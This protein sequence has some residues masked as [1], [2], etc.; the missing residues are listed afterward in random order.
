M[1]NK[2][3]YSYNV[4]D[5]IEAVKETQFVTNNHPLSKFF[6]NFNFIFFVTNTP[7]IGEYSILGNILFGLLT[8]VPILLAVAFTTLAERKIMASLQRRR[9]PNVVGSWGLGQPII[10]GCK[11]FFKETI[12]PGRSNFFL[13]WCTP[14]LSVSFSL[15]GWGLIAFSWSKPICD[16]NLGL[17]AIFA[18][19]SL[20]TYSL[21]IAA[22]SSNSRYSLLGC[23]RAV[24]Q[25][26]SYELILGFSILFVAH[27]SD[28]LNLTSIVVAQTNVFFI[29]PL[30]PIAILFFI[31]MLA[32][33]NRVPFDLPEAE[34]ELVSGYSTEYS[35]F[36][37]SLIMIAE[38]SNIL[39]L[40]SLW[41]IMF[42][43]GWLSP[44]PFFDF[45]AP[46]AIFAFK[47]TFL[48]FIF[49]FARSLL[50][51]YRFDQLMVICWKLFIPFLIGAVILYFGFVLLF[52]V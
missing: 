40:S 44:L 17:F 33:T 12:L 35:A 29:F 36:L 7:F 45:L 18:L 52:M 16:A 10:D 49:I 42:W 31:M 2:L 51:R 24:S 6:L 14:L 25:L 22:W 8:I 1:L 19:A 30:F 43:G 13:F 20:N 48:V 41:V 34:S 38:Y 9:G 28:S 32:E 27:L 11:L 4:V 39:L 23:L 3:I 21:I 37:F 15:T 26:I 46:E 5:P 50:P 47:V